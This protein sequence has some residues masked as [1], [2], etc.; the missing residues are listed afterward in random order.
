MLISKKYFFLMFGI[1]LVLP[2]ISANCTANNE[3]EQ[4]DE[5]NVC[6]GNC[7][8]Q[9]SSN[10]SQ[11]VD[12]DDNVECKFTAFYP[13]DTLITAYKTMSR[14]G[15]IYNYSLGYINTTG[16]YTWNYLCYANKGWKAET[17]TF[18]ISEEAV[19][20]PPSGG[21]GFGTPYPAEPAPEEVV[22]E[23]EEEEI[24]TIEYIE[25]EIIAPAKEM[26]EYFGSFISPKYPY[27][28]LFIIIFLAIVIYI[29]S[30][31]HKDAIIKKIEKQRREP[32]PK[33]ISLR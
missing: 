15:N 32:K 33:P 25:E 1:L 31:R 29:V 21:G 9:N 23:A 12:C 26:V 3:F 17:T 16:T 27:L 8:Y 13:N 11:Y 2:L 30:V 4:G 6:T 14:D 24:T 28:G 7:T 18:S 22:Y 19:T 20:P 5:I 10:L